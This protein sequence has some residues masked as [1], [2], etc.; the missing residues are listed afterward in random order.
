MRIN[1]ISNY[2]NSYTP[3]FGVNLNSP[4]LKFKEDDF[5]V[6]IK[7]YGHDSG[8]AKKIRETADKAVIYIREN[9]NFENT[10][11][12]ICS[13]VT[14]ANQLPLDLEKRKHTGVLRI[15][16][17]GWY[18]QSDWGHDSGLITAYSKTNRYKD[19]ADRFDYIVKHPLK[20]PYRI[21]LT[22]PVHDKDLGKFLDHG[23]A[24]YINTAFYH[25]KKIYEN[26]Y[27]KY[28]TNEVK[29]ENLEDVNC[30]I[31]EI[32]WILAHATPWERGSDA[33]ANTFVRSI[34]KAIGIKT[35]PLKKGI[36]LDL[37]AY[38]TELDEYKRRFASYFVK[39]PMIID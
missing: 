26:L 39:K 34:Y 36:S 3:T 9:C 31:A 38:C 13:G 14:E 25:A 10:L 19:Y 30:S 7:G 37:E 32:R 24:K 17:E 21:E 12:K 16:R 8:W 22:R 28:I 11:K 18:Y 4:K 35:T 6:R 29:K 2:Y 27:S 15:P 33:I 20:N 1:S 5:Y 23:S